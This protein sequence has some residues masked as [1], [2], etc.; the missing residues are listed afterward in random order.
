[1]SPDGR[2]FAE[3]ILR[4]IETKIHQ[5]YSLSSLSGKKVIISMKTAQTISF[6][7]RLNIKAEIHQRKDQ[8]KRKLKEY[9]LKFFLLWYVHTRRCESNAR[10]RS[11]EKKCWLA[12]L[13]T[14]VSSSQRLLRKS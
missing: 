11:F 12:R 1:M 8:T 2:N 7:V 10:Y 4:H 5:Q 9:F 6:T 14:S 3:V 13:L